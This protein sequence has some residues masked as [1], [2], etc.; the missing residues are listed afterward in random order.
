MNDLINKNIVIQ[1]SDLSVDA[2]K[3]E[4]RMSDNELQS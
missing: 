3:Q 2:S 4:Y 1:N